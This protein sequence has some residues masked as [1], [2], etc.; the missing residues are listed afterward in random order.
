MFQPFLSKLGQGLHTALWGA[1]SRKT[2]PLVGSC[3]R[4]FRFI[5]NTFRQ[6]GWATGKIQLTRHA[7]AVSTAS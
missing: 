5:G 6:E 2:M 3:I 1:G 7:D 4:C